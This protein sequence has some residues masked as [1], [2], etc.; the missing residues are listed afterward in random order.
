MEGLK[1]EGLESLMWNQVAAGPV[2]VV[3]LQY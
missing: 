3:W 2:V 1:T